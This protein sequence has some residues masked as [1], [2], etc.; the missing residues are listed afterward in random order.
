VRIVGDVRG[1]GPELTYDTVLTAMTAAGYLPSLLPGAYRSVHGLDLREFPEHTADEFRVSAA[2]I[3]DF[4]ARVHEGSKR[5]DL[6][7]P[8]VFAFARMPPARSAWRPARRH[9]VRADFPAAAR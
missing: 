6:S 4:V 7:R 1:V 8:A 9:M 5:E 2:L 3:E